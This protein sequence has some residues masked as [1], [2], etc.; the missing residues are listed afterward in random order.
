MNDDASER[1]CNLLGIEKALIDE[2]ALVG[3]H[4][5]PYKSV[6]NLESNIQRKILQ[7][8]SLLKMALRPDIDTDTR[9]NLLNEAERDFITAIEDLSTTKSTENT[10]IEIFCKE[11][12]GII[13]TVFANET[14]T[15]VKKFHYYQTAA[16]YFTDAVIDSK[17]SN[18][19]KGIVSTERIGTNAP[20]LF[21][22]VLENYNKY[23]NYDVKLIEKLKS[24]LSSDALS[25]MESYN[26]C[27]NKH[28]SSHEEGCESS[29]IED[30]VA[31][32]NEQASLG[33]TIPFGTKVRLLNSNN[34][35]IFDVNSIA[36]IVNY[37]KQTQKYKIVNA[38]LGADWASS[39]DF[40]VY[41]GECIDNSQGQCT[42]PVL[43]CSPGTYK[44][45]AQCKKCPRHTYSSTE[46]A[47]TCE[48]CPA[49]SDTPDIG[50]SYCSLCPK[51]TYRP[52]EGFKEAVFLPGYGV[53]CLK[54]NPYEHAT[55]GSA[56]CTFSYTEFILAW[57]III[58]IIV[59]M[60][61]SC[62]CSKR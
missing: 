28:E 5:E 12:V 43:T 10:A 25:E 23:S 19:K 53:H 8:S 60:I 49:G 59:I 26:L 40:E 62:F 61:A 9:V 15:E 55:P 6:N 44:N 58:V 34:L 54:C 20:D 50:A 3:L 51:D 11:K 16:N 24:S 52:E 18:I 48:K 2:A 39:S 21:A 31:I 30:F 4:V 17:N 56:K 41:N 46:N 1:P 29:F 7:G 33:N 13:N 22:I 45:G 47:L 57:T 14:A 32:L 36:T 27:R 35:S 42:F 38:K 37:D